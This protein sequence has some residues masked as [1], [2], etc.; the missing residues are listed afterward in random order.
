[1]NVK[2]KYYREFT[3]LRKTRQILMFPQEMSNVP[4]HTKQDFCKIHLLYFK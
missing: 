4:N 2:T 1:M 3:Y